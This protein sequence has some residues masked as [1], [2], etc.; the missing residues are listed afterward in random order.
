MGAMSDQLA[1][2]IGDRPKR[3][4]D[5]ELRGGKTVR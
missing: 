3:R 2:A 4:A 5:I 1:I